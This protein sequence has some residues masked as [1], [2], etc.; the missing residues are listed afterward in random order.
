MST[1]LTLAEL[2][3]I[4]IPKCGVVNFGALH[5]VLRGILEHLHLE[6]L[7]KD[8]SGD[9]DFLQTSGMPKPKED[10]AQPILPSMKQLVDFDQVLSRIDKLESQLSS[11]KDLPSTAQLL[12]GSMGTRRPMED[13]WNF[14]RLQKKTES[15][16]EAITKAM[17]ILQDLLI[18]LHLFKVTVDSLKKDMDKLRDIFEKIRPEKLD[19]VAEG[20]RMESRRTSALQREVVTIQ[21]KLQN[22]PKPEEVV[23]WSSLHEAMFTGALVLPRSEQT[24]E[25]LPAATF[26]QR[27]ALE[28]GVQ[29]HTSLQRTSGHYD[30]TEI[31]LEPVEVVPLRGLGLGLDLCL[32]LDL[33]LGLHLGLNLNLHLDLDLR[34]GLGL[35]L[36]LD[37]CQGQGAW[38]FLDLPAPGPSFSLQPLPTQLLAAI[39]PSREIG[40]SWPS[41]LKPHQSHRTGPRQLPA[42]EEMEDEYSYPRRKGAPQEE[43]PRRGAQ[44][45][46]SSEAHLKHPGS[47]L[48]RAKTTAAVA[49]ATAAAYAAAATSAA[50][51]AHAAAKAIKEA[52]ATKLATRAPSGPFSD[53]LG[54]GS[55]RG[56]TV[57]TSL[58]DDEEEEDM[59]ISVG[60]FSPSYTS[61]SLPRLAFSQAMILG[62]QAVS[63]EDKK[64]AV[65]YS[66]SH[67]AQMPIT[68]DSLKTE[69]S[70][71]STNLQ[72][73]LTYLGKIKDTSRFGATLESLQEK[74][75]NL[76][77]SRLQEEELERIWGTQIES[78]KN[79]Y[80]V[81]DRAIGRLQNRLDDFKSLQPQID[82]LNR[83][84]V[85]KSTMDKE[86]KEK[87]EKSAL[88]SKVNRN[89]LD[90]I[91]TE[92]NEMVQSVLFK[93]T[94]YEE[95][96]KK[97]LGQFKKDL[98]TKLVP[99]DLEAMK[100]D[101]EEIWRVVLK[102]VVDSLRFDP[103]CAAGFRKKLFERVKCISCD[104]P[105]KMMTSPQLI[106]IRK[107]NLPSRL[108]PASANG[109]EYLEQ[110]LLREQKLQIQDLDPLGT[111]QDWGDGPRNTATRQRT[112][113]MTTLYPYGD[114]EELD[115][116][117]AEVDILGVDGVLYKGRMNTQIGTQPPLGEKELTA[118]KIPCPPP[119]A[120]PP[121]DRMRSNA[122]T[123]AVH[124]PPGFPGYRT[125]DSATSR[126]V[127]T[128]LS[129]PPSMLPLLPLVIPPR[130]DSLQ[131]QV[132]PRHQ[133]FAHLESRI[134]MPSAEESTNSTNSTVSK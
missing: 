63:P 117:T 14:I 54:I 88:A 22:I 105:V 38:P 16:E 122:L 30:G 25:Q 39:P 97:A 85:N 28:D 81:L 49:A 43:T 109:Y 126:P 26:A 19:V 10:A 99:N 91:A 57:S 79:Q 115:Y 114:P 67:I 59:Q 80:V 29:R 18:E 84:K 20:L 82:R 8:L 94:T 37:L 102:L 5:L 21:T 113:N 7:K 15:N 68:Q 70:K 132:P 112:Y 66:M 50:R 35:D 2:T 93:V 42:V 6:E 127:S 41:P 9:E 1:S 71:L 55:S 65:Q 74:L 17:Q 51:A 133:R 48:K 130:G 98:A 90:V 69:F 103:D 13:L 11:L 44:V 77:K 45:D 12:Q 36:H 129:R 107:G 60:R 56:A 96:W 61:P 83:E 86:L 24:S 87:A 101:I 40:Y 125:G 100:K 31:Q 4:A 104:R 119:A 46:A 72:Q 27:E 110:E 32:G 92:L 58:S 108:R 128:T 121:S 76:Q 116:D 106:T 34:L 111:Q 52:S 95:D 78:M 47:G 124:A 33:P 118:V 3:N 64:K 53:S 73:R 131:A 134:T 75:N 23:L 123:G 62:S 120:Q 89:E